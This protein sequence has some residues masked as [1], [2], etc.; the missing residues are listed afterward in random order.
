MR[1]EVQIVLGTLCSYTSTLWGW[2]SSSWS[3]FISS[4]FALMSHRPLDSTW[5]PSNDINNLKYLV[6]DLKPIKINFYIRLYYLYLPFFSLLFLSSNWVTTG[7]LE[8]EVEMPILHI[9]NY[10]Y[11]LP[12]IALT[13]PHLGL[14]WHWK[15]YESYISISSI[16]SFNLQYSSTVWFFEWQ[17]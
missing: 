11:R 15:C 14:P 8:Q 13:R 12:S 6:L 9:L 10:E 17:S 2:W 7:I 1:L 3:A 5:I 4:I 16:L